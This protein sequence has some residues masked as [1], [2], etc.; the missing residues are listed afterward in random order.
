M[1]F[2]F[3]STPVLVQMAV[4]VSVL[5]LWLTT[6]L[7]GYLSWPMHYVAHSSPS[8]TTGD[9]RKHSLLLIKRF[10]LQNLTPPLCSTM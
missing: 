5:Y 6:H 8:S 10:H 3:S 1:E 7:F 2:R 4:N 9:W